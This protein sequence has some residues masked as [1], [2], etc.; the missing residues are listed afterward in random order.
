MARFRQQDG[1][2]TG[3]W[4]YLHLQQSRC[5][6]ELTCCCPKQSQTVMIVIAQMQLQPEERS[7][8]M[9][10]EQLSKLQGQCR[11]G[12][13]GAAWAR[14]EISLQPVAKTMLKQLCLCS[15]WKSVAQRWMCSPWRK[16]TLE[17][18]FRC[19]INSCD[20]VELLL[21]GLAEPW[22]ENTMLEQVSW[23]ESWP[24]WGSAVKLPVS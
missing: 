17:Q 6:Q 21:A 15:P 10:A 4:S 3:L 12:G 5:L 7:E 14:A 16:P 24:L 13:G 19:L 2:A 20:P 18:G 9:W 23:L 1:E 22:R 8:D 11:G